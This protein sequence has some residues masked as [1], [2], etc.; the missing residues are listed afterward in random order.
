MYYCARITAATKK[1]TISDHQGMLKVIQHALT[2]ANLTT[3][4][5]A[6]LEINRKIATMGGGDYHRVKKLASLCSSSVCFFG[7]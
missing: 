5:P 1:T 6:L 3:D 7:S 4:Q 2:I